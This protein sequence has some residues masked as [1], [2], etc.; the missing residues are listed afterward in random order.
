MLELKMTV[1]LLLFLSLLFPNCHHLNF[2]LDWA[3]ENHSFYLGSKNAS[4][5]TIPNSDLNSARPEFEGDYSIVSK[6]FADGSVD[7]LPFDSSDYSFREFA[8]DQSEI[9]MTAKIASFV[10]A[11]GGSRWLSSEPSVAPSSTSPYSNY[12]SNAKST[13]TAVGRL[14]TKY[15]LFDYND[16]HLKELSFISTAFMV[17]PDLLVTS[18]HSLF[19]DP[20]VASIGFDDGVHNPR[21]PDEALFFPYS[22]ESRFPNGV[23]IE[24]I[25]IEKAFYLSGERDWGCAKLRDS[26]GQQTGYFGLIRSFEEPS[27]NVR[28]LGFAGKNGGD[29]SV[30]KGKIL[31][32][33]SGGGYCSDLDSSAGQSGSPVLMRLNG[34]EYAVGINDYGKGSFSGGIVIDDFI[35]G[36]ID[37]FLGA[38]NVET[39]SIADEKIL[40]FEPLGKNDLMVDAITPSGIKYQT[41]Q[42][43]ASIEQRTASKRTDDNAIYYEY[44]FRRPLVQVAINFGEAV[45]SAASSSAS[46]IKLETWND[47]TKWSYRIPLSFN[48]SSSKT[49]TAKQTTIVFDDLVYRFRIASYGL[50]PESIDVYLETGTYF[51]LNGSELPYEPEKWNYKPVVNYTNCYSY[52][53]NNQVYPGTNTLFYMRPGEYHGVMMSNLDVNEIVQAC[54]R[55]FAKYSNTFH[56]TY[57]FG[58]IGKYAVPPDGM[59]KVALLVADSVYYRDFH[60]MR[61][62]S[63]GYWSHKKGSDPA[64]RNDLDKYSYNLITDPETCY[65]GFYEFCGFYAVHPWNN[66][67][68]EE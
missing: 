18:G 23:E 25:Y 41:R 10:S 9:E 37:S 26:I 54:K 44:S 24:R 12:L 38:T 57:L 32:F 13:E 64:R 53:I 58:S 30:S 4:F 14:L 29:L 2:N 39:I 5:S 50:P 66:M 68:I 34:E 3:K 15:R 8:F 11:S 35:F 17:G 62:D 28:M 60:F 52:A 16:N 42:Y 19:L 45:D 33:D 43:A 31:S 36:F 20:S 56:H 63:D 1:R 40:S 48:E 6:D 21:F 55:D 51:P 61:Q 65:L 59:Y 47:E 46:K 27:Q 67:Y 7:F 22:L 49:N